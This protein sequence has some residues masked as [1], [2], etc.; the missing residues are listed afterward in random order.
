MIDVR[1]VIP[2]L[3]EARNLPYAFRPNCRRVS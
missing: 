2:G 3:N 1:A